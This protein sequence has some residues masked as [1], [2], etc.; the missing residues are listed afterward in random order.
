MT[1]LYRVD[2]GLV[3]QPIRACCRGIQRILQPR[4]RIRVLDV[5]DRL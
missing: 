4:S 2:M 1:N 5:L 3:D